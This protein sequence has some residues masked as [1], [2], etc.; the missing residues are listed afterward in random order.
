MK[1]SESFSYC[2]LVVINIMAEVLVSSK[3]IN[4]K[5]ATR[6]K[7][8]VRRMTALASITHDIRTV[9]NTS[10]LYFH[11]DILDPIIGAVY[12]HSTEAN[13]LQY[14]LASFCD[15]IRLC[16]AVTHRDSTPFL[17]EYRSVL[18]RTLTTQIVEPLCRDIETDLR[19]HVHTK[20]L[21]HVQTLNPKTENLRPLRPFLDIAPLKILGLVINIKNEV[22]HYLDLNFYNLTTVALHDWRTYSDMRSLAQEKLGLQLMDNFL[23]MGSLDQGLDVLQIMRNIHIFV[24]RFAYNMNTQTFVEFRPDKQSKHLNTIKIQVSSPS[25]SLS[26]SLSSSSSSSLSS[27]HILEYRSI[28]PPARPWHPQHDS[29]LHVPVSCPEVQHLQPVPV[30]R[31]HP[32]TPRQGA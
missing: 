6:L 18:K 20:H 7:Q 16:Q 2:R 10:F 15:G 26:S 30:R 29:E 24:S 17:L 9:C 5:D 4:E 25:S 12:Q 22:T 23:P 3:Y 14:I 21:N 32:C 27:S 19:L 31:L 1:S 13:R 8:L 11:T 28:Y